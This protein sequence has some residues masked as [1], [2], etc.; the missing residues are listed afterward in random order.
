MSAREMTR[1]RARLFIVDALRAALDPRTAKLSE[2]AT[3]H[4][5]GLGTDDDVTTWA[6]VFEAAELFSWHAS[7]LRK[8]NASE[9]VR[10]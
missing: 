3:F 9:A 2:A 6:E 1:E 8:A 5:H 7:A 4:P 10:P